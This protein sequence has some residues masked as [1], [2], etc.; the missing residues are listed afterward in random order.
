MGWPK[1]P[2]KILLQRDFDKNRKNW[3]QHCCLDPQSEAYFC[4]KPRHPRHRGNRLQ[5]EADVGDLAR[6]SNAWA[7]LERKD[8]WLHMRRWWWRLTNSRQH[9]KQSHQEQSK[10]EFIKFQSR[11]Q[12]E[13]T[14]YRYRDSWLL[15][16]H[17]S[18]YHESHLLYESV[19]LPQKQ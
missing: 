1:S 2:C 16:G 15:Y 12:T 17:Y 14:A 6:R 11:L 18:C 9:S 4:K 10:K 8:D 19:I 7:G 3:I 13:Q 5:N